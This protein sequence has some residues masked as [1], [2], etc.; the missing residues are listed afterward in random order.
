MIF[1]ILHDDND[2]ELYRFFCFCL[3]DF[4]IMEHDRLF[5]DFDF[6]EFINFLVLSEIIKVFI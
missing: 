5:N 6:F 4:V 3:N 1:Y 2:D